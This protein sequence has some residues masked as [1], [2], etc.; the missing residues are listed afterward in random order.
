MLDEL[1]V[2][3]CNGT[4]KYDLNELK[5][6]ELF[7]LNKLEFRLSLVTP[8]SIVEFMIGHGIFFN[9]EQKLSNSSSSEKIYG[10]PVYKLAK[11]IIEYTLEGN[12][13]IFN[14]IRIKIMVI[15]NTPQ[16]I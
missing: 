11:D 7:C 6:F 2:F 13:N 3:F 12:K 16:F 9:D 1:G 4:I 10:D 5:N 14:I 15:L 8:F